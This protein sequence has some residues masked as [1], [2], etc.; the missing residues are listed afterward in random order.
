[1]LFVSSHFKLAVG[2]KGKQLFFEK[3]FQM[4]TRNYI[5][6]ARELL[7]VTENFWL[8][9]YLQYIQIMLQIFVKFLV[10]VYSTSGAIQKLLFGCTFCSL[11]LLHIQQLTKCLNYT[12]AHKF[13]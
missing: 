7:F 11:G 1:M 3:R 13:L 12:Q 8:F 2:S 9:Q 5:Q 10:I 4:I 6:S